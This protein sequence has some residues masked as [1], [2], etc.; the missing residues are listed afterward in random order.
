MSSDNT[1]HELDAKSETGSEAGSDS[2]SVVYDHE[3]FE[4]FQSRVLELCQ[5]VLGFANGGVSIERMHGGGFNRIIGV[6]VSSNEGA[7]LSQYVVRVPRFE[8]AQLE[9][10]LAPLRLLSQRKSIL[11]PDVVA[12]DTTGRNVLE[13]P[14]MLQT[15]I[16][17][18]SLF[19]T[20]PDVSHATKC[21]IAK[22]LGKVYSE[23]LSINSVTAGRLRL[24][25]S[26]ESLTIQPFH[27]PEIT[28]T[29]HYQEGPAAQ[30]T[31]DMLRASLDHQMELA[32]AQGP[33][34]SFR[35]SFF[36]QFIA[37]ASEMNALGV[38]DG[39]YYSLCHLD[40]E[41]RNILVRDP[42]PNQPH[43]ISGIL[44]WDSAVFA[45]P[46]MSCSPPMWLWAW[47]DEDEEDELLAND[48]PLTAELCQ[49][50]QLFEHAAGPI[51][52]RYAYDA[53]YRLA[54]KIIRFT[55]DGLRSNEDLISAETVLEEWNQVRTSLE[56]VKGALGQPQIGSIL[57]T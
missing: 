16:P 22:E 57:A 56:G 5:T 33:N 51:Y 12:F 53:Q 40:L 24:S 42:T 36:D 55:I 27:N 11:T 45:P 8:A 28:A 37:A 7:T 44:D 1:A 15:R 38:L 47:N 54:R 39:N 3:P 49:L 26:H 4:N 52:R 9:F 46:L 17:G 43:A 50:K 10:E 32:A 2:S 23:L 18:S 30:T 25:P 21:A 6:S 14:Y 35:I 19:L 29:A 34:Q 48:A 41:P 13:S 20:Y 31:F